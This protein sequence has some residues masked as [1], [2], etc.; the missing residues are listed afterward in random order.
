V[1]HG[2]AAPVGT[3]VGCSDDGPLVPALE[4]RRIRFGQ[5]ALASRVRHGDTANAEHGQQRAR[6][7]LG[8]PLLPRLLPCALHAHDELLFFRGPARL[9]PDHVL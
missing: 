5:D 7:L 8:A 2:R 4:P 1:C 3:S 6:R 9:L